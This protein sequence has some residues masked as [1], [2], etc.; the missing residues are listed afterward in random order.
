MPKIFLYNTLSRKKE[1]F[2]PINKN[3]ITADNLLHNFRP[4]DFG[5]LQANMSDYT[6]LIDDNTRFLNFK[7]NADAAGDYDTADYNN[8]D[9]QTG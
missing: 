5:I 9:Y 4:N 8:T 6:K 2:K 7:L 3:E 1:E